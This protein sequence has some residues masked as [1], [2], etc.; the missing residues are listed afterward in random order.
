MTYPD[1]FALVAKLMRRFNS[2]A[3]RQEGAQGLPVGIREGLR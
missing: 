1:D 2:P 3:A